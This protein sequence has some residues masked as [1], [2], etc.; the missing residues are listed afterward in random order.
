[1]FNLKGANFGR[2]LKVFNR[3]Y[4]MLSRNSNLSIG[5]NFVFT[6]GDGLN[7]LCRNIR[8]KIYI[9]EN[10]TVVIGNN[11]GI[12]SACIWAK[13]SIRIGNRVNIGGDCIIMDTDAHNLDWKVRAGLIRVSEKNKEYGDKNGFLS[14]IKTALAEPIIIEDDVLVGTR[15]IILKGAKIGARSIVAAGSVVTKSFPS[16][17]IIGG[18]PA[19]IIRNIENQL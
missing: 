8:G 7:P 17:V 9:E 11:T 18:N 1:M 13:K 15:C 19:K 3:F 16:D 6:S 5:D 4:L 14:D 12:S 2:N 10:A